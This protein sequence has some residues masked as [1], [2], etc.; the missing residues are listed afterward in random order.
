VRDDVGRVA[1]RSLEL[2]VVEAPCP[3]GD[4]GCDEPNPQP[5]PGAPGTSDGGC[6]SVR[7]STVA[8]ALSLIAWF[9]L[10]LAL[11]LSRRRF[12]RRG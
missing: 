4:P 12:V 3:D 11:R 10:G 6:T 2:S 5:G 8:D 9:A 7:I 1:R